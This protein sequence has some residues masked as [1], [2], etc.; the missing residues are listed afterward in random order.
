[1]TTASDVHIVV[2]AA[3]VDVVIIKV[4]LVIDNVM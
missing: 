3:A 1:M 4:E 2:V